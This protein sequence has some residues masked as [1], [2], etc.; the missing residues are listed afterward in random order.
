MKGL[1]RKDLYFLENSLKMLVIAMIVIGI[2]VSFL[3][4]T[5]IFIIIFPIVLGSVILVTIPKEKNTKWD[6]FIAMTPLS[7]D[8]L[9]NSK[10]LLYLAMTT[11]GIIIGTVVTFLSY[12]FTKE[13]NFMNLY[14]S[15]GLSISVSL[16]SGGI[17]IPINFLW[18]EERAIIGQISSYSL[19]AMFLVAVLYGINLF[20][21]VKDNIE[22]IIGILGVISIIFYMFSWSIGKKKVLKL[23]YN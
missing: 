17:S 19:I 15:I 7:K 21:P 8:T 22:T 12:I 18:S 4:S 10:Y 13:V 9:L 23:E 5:E 20:I 11:L 16:L 6:K 2:G 1:I 3:I 14:S